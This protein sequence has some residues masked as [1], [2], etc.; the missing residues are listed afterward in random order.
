MHAVF[1]G[2]NNIKLQ[3]TGILF[4]VALF[5]KITPTQNT[6]IIREITE[7]SLNSVPYTYLKI[8]EKFSLIVYITI[9]YNLTLLTFFSYCHKFLTCTGVQS[10]QIIAH[11]LPIV[12]REN[13]VSVTNT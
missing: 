9:Q 12:L 4:V 2:K 8:G 6:T 3:T 13:V 5:Y 10:E 7:N 11:N 1:Q